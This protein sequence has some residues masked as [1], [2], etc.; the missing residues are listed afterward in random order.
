MPSLLHQ[1]L[2]KLQ[3]IHGAQVV[4][5]VTFSILAYVFRPAESAVTDSD[6]WLYVLA[7]I[8]AVTTAGSVM[9]FKVL[10]TNARQQKTLEQKLMKYFVA[11]LSRLAFLELPGLMA[12]VVVLVTGNLQAYV[13]TLLVLILFFVNRPNIVLLAEELILSGEEKAK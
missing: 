7:I 6:L 13:A 4:V 11:S 2:Q 12:G 5:L 8:T 10:L 1:H 3:I 9:V